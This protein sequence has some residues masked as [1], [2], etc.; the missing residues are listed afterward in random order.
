M[1]WWSVNHRGI[2][3]F[4]NKELPDFYKE[5]FYMG[6]L[7]CLMKDANSGGRLK[8]FSCGESN[9][10]EEAG[11]MFGGGFLTLIVIQI[12]ELLHPWHDFLPMQPYQWEK[13]KSLQKIELNSSPG[14]SVKGFYLF[15]FHVLYSGFTYIHKIQKTS[16]SIKSPNVNCFNKYFAFLLVSTMRKMPSSL[17]KYIY[18]YINRTLGLLHIC[19]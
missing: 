14:N 13:C 16:P 15:W 7:I 18:I 5:I 8:L 2:L 9:C 3:I 19:T 11:S 4:S 1:K 10:W 17:I 6:T 12:T